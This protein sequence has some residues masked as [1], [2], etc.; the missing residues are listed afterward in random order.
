MNLHRQIAD[1]F[2]D[3]YR[4]RQEGAYAISPI[5]RSRYNR[6]MKLKSKLALIRQEFY[7][8]SPTV[9]KLDNERKLRV[10]IPPQEGGDDDKDKKD[11]AEK[12]EDAEA[13]AAA[14]A[15]ALGEEPDDKKK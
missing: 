7:N 11:E 4:K 8:D 15:K 14:A 3:L 6:A 10:R 2:L 9:F 12:K 1:S 13:E 5:R